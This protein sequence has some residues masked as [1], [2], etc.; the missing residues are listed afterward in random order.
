MKN[1]KIK[2]LQQYLK[3]I[4][5]SN[6]LAILNALKKR[7]LCVCEIFLLLNLPQNLTSHHLKILKDTGLI[8]SKRNGVKIVYSRNERIINDY[9]TL[10]TNIIKL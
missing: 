9:Q 8:D 10:L 4:S 6:R 5:D 3:A 1:Y 2:N 7:P